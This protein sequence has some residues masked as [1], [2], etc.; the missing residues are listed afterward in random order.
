MTTFGRLSSFKCGVMFLQRFSQKLTI[1]VSINFCSGNAFMPQ[2]FL[3]SPKV[4]TAFNQMRGKRMA[5]CMRRNCFLNTCFLYKIFNNVKYHYPGEFASPLVEKKNILASML[6]C[7]M[8][9]DFIFINIDI[10]YSASSNRYQS[11]FITFTNH[12]NKANI[13]VKLRDSQVNYF[14][15]PQAATIHHFQYCFITATFFFAEINL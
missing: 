15:Y 1:K 10:L 13:E 8:N 7:N 4:S 6:Y 11:F 12:T 14:T 9:P 2:H 5:E 3:Y